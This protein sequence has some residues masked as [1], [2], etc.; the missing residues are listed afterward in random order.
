M[1]TR[2]QLKLGRL[3]GKV[4]WIQGLAG[5]GRLVLITL[6]VLLA[7]YVLDRS[8]RLPLA[9]RAVLVVAS[10]ATVVF[11]IRRVLVRPLRRTYLDD[12]LASG[13]EALHPE[14]RDRIRSTLDFQSALDRGDLA[15]SPAM[16]QHVIDE[17]LRD[18]ESVSFRGV[19]RIRRAVPWL[20]AALVAVLGIG[21]WAASA[22]SHVGI[23]FRRFALLDPSASWPR[24]TELRV[25][26]PPDGSAV[27]VTDEDGVT[28]FHVAKGLDFT[29]NVVA[30]R[31]DPK[32]VALHFEGTGA[33]RS[34]T[35]TMPR[36]AAQRY[37]TTFERLT[38]SFRFHVTGGDDDDRL[39]TYRV[40]VHDAP[41]VAE[42]AV[43]ATFPSY[44]GRDPQT[45]PTGDVEVPLDTSLEFR[46]RA[47]NAVQSGRIAI[48]AGRDGDGDGEPTYIPLARADDGHYRAVVAATRDFDYSIEL[49]GERRVT[50]H[51][52]A[53]YRVLTVPDGPPTVRIAY[54]PK[55]VVAA[56]TKAYLPLVASV[57]DDYGVADLRLRLLRGPRPS[58]EAGDKGASQDAELPFTRDERIARSDDGDPLGDRAFH[59][60]KTLE[61]KSLEVPDDT[62]VR[63]PAPGDVVRMLV[64]AKDNHRTGGDAPAD[65]PNT[66]RSRELRIEILRDADLER[67]INDSQLKVKGAV[68]RALAYQ[69][70]TLAEA[71]DVATSMRQPSGDGS[72]PVALA[73]LANQLVAVERRQ[74]RLTTDLRGV[75]TQLRLNLDAHAFNRLEVSPVTDRIIDVFVG[76]MRARPGDATFRFRALLDAHRRGAIGQSDV[77][78]KL[79]EMV[80]IAG[81][82]AD[83]ASPAA[84]R[85]MS[86][87]RAGTDRAALQAEVDNAVRHQRRCEA[88]LVALLDGLR[89][90]E[91]Y[92]EVI[93]L[94]KELIE[95]QQDI[96][97]RTID[98]IKNRGGTGTGR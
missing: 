75:A 64:E 8:L 82:A 87:A 71:A 61:V 42:L 15:E 76:A 11:A 43:V 56:T 54:P 37:T 30:D 2:L 39:P 96:E 12:D 94:N 58:A 32:E 10:I 83:E 72:A 92:Q 67:R 51:G 16:A 59:A 26:M 91:D 14:L 55:G 17:T 41:A 23:W 35:R 88:L 66:G 65:A 79:I 45:F 7:T 68:Q 46:V 60:L 86:A 47:T 36:V 1:Q 22:D 25:L 63:A 93:Q 20:A 28:V 85:A 34:G 90:W 69:R 27:H 52:R 9:V 81:E 80:G 33:A 29:V 44:V 49:V 95:L 84:S 77:L 70:R 38:A 6:A 73:E 13:V 48:A 4:K 57:R 19:A 89:E 62:G 5:I 74:S 21:I 50:N 40:R 31:G 18:I 98:L 97:N 53:R 78:T 24:S 3:R